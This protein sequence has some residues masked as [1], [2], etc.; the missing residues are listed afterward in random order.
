LRDDD[1]GVRRRA[2]LAAGRIGDPAL[3]PVLLE[4]LEDA[5]PEVR[6]MTAFALGLI[7]D[8]SAA[9][10]LT[11]ALSDPVAVVRARS[12]EALGRIGGPGVAEAVARR[13]AA[14]TPEGA[15]VLT[16]RGDDPGSPTDP[17]LELRLS[18][19]ALARL[20]D[21]RAAES[22][23]LRAGRSRYDWWAA[24]WTAMRIESPALKP[25]LQAASASTDAV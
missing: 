16:I 1:R 18:L 14:A 19:F 4:L 7:G 15:E 2:A 8:K 20:K 11:L 21:A 24:T 6:Q 3:V 10:R 13:A 12:V 17:W 23:L 5:E 9:A 25:V 22:V